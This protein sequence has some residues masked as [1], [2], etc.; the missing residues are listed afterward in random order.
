MIAPDYRQIIA[1]LDPR[2]REKLLTRS[3]RS[4]LTH[5]AGHLSLLGVTGAWI[6]VGAPGWQAAMVFHGIT[7]IFLFTLLHECTH[8]TPFEN[9]FLNRAVG[10]ICGLF[11]FLPY[12][13]FTYFHLAHHRFTHDPERDPELTEPKPRSWSQYL[14]YLSGITIWWSQLSK[15]VLTAAHGGEI[16]QF[17]PGSRHST[18]RREARAHLAAYGLLAAASIHAGSTMLIWLWILPAVIGQPF[19]RLYLLAEHTLCPH[20]A[21]MLENTRTTYTTALVRFLAW[22]MPYHTEHHCY[23]EVPFHQLPRLHNII[24]LQLQH[25]ENG[26]TAFHRR[27]ARS[28]AARGL[29]GPRRGR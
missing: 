20:V 19:L 24:R 13:W 3:D 10:T 4:G 9:A 22:N 28:R 6:L 17:V 23:P 14:V 26:Y 21:N 8:N 29:W 25:T 11:L 7:L 15:L 18:I 12:R 27:F 5:L 2:E 1:S 16:D